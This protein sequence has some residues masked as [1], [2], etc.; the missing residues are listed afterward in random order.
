MYTL[1]CILLQL[2]LVREAV[3]ALPPSRVLGLA[4]SLVAAADAAIKVGGRRERCGMRS[5]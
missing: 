4:D 1:L 5:W 3:F 2:S